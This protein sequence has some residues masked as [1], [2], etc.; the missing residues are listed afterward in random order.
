MSQTV[1]RLR[2]HP[3]NHD[4]KRQEAVHCP[5]N[6]GHSTGFLGFDLALISHVLPMYLAC[7]SQSPPKHLA[8]TT[9]VPR[10]YL[11]LGGFPPPFIIHPSSFILHFG[12]ALMSHWSGFG[13]ASA[14]FLHSS[15]CLLPSPQCGFGWPSPRRFPAALRRSAVWKTRAL[16]ARFP[17]RTPQPVSP[18]ST[19]QV[20]QYTKESEFVNCA[21]Q[22]CY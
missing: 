7:T 6:A 14:A 10:I 20:S 11:A 17:A 16:L 2:Q 4:C 13:V 22:I 21:L 9:H 18:A 3:R 19:R 5:A 8:R 12:V 1:G 15:F